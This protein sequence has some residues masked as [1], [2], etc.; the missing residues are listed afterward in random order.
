MKFIYVYV[1]KK[2]ISNVTLMNK[3]QINGLLQSMVF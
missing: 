2:N 1:P 3:T